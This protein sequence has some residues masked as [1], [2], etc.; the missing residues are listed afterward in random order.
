MN[1]KQIITKTMIYKSDALIEGWYSSG[2]Q[3]MCA[4]LL[5]PHPDLGGQINNA[6]LRLINKV[7]SAIGFSTLRIN[8]RGIGMSKGMLHDSI[9]DRGMDLNDA[10]YCLDWLSS[11]HSD[12]KIL[13][14]GGFG[15]GGHVGINVAMRRPGVHGFVSISPYAST[16]NSTNEFSTLTPCP[17]GLIIVGSEDRMIRPNALK[18]IARDLSN[19]KGCS[20]FFKEL[21]LANHNYSDHREDLSAMIYDYI[22]QILSQEQIKSTSINLG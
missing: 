16:N 14:V 2:E 6:V 10:V 12:P 21:K 22:D 7:F 1:A 20:I 18:R 9:N 13:W 5:P 3:S 11:K 17:N 4:L 8:F 19:Q 15:Y